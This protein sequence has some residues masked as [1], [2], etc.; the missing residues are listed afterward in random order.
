MSQVMESQETDF[1]EL[2]NANKMTDELW[3]EVEAYVKEK[4]T[5]DWEDYLERKQHFDDAFYRKNSYDDALQKLAQQKGVIY[6]HVLTK[7]GVV[8]PSV[9]VKTKFG[10]A[11][12]VKNS[13]DKN[14]EV[15]EWVNVSV[16]NTVQKQ[17]QHYAKKG[18]QL[19]LVEVRGYIYNGKVYPAWSDIKS[20]EVLK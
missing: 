10:E 12:V 17:Q 7:D 18:Y 20:I 3:Q 8:V 4:V 16:A 15:V 19:A 5:K 14:A 1:Y 6:E 13:W 2:I 11:F 9:V